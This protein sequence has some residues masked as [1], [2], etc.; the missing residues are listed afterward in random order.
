MPSH[1]VGL[2]GVPFESAGPSEGFSVDAK[3]FVIAYFAQD[4]N[5]G[6]PAREN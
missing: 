5:A 6:L 3:E 2:C 4:A 1:T